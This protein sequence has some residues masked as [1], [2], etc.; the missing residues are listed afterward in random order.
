M[1]EI[2][3]GGSEPGDC[4]NVG[5]GPRTGR[6]DTGCRVIGTTR[7]VGVE[8]IDVGLGEGSKVLAVQVDG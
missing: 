5:F 7:V 1:N 3:V 8:L 6:I 4:R 2:V